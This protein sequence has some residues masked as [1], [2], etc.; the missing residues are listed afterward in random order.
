MKHVINRGIILGSL[1]GVTLSTSLACRPSTEQ[2]GSNL[3]YIQNGDFNCAS[4]PADRLDAVKKKLPA[5]FIEDFPSNQMDTVYN[6]VS[7]IPDVYLD[8]LVSQYKSGVLEGIRTSGGG[9]FGIAGVTTLRSGKS[10]KGVS[11]MVATEIAT[12]P[13]KAGF[14]MQHEIGH[15][16]EI[17]AK[18]A[19]QNTEFKDFSGTLKRINKEIS[20][21]GDARSYAKS[22]PGESWAETYAN[23][24]CNPDTNA[25]IKNNL[26]YTWN[27]V[28]TVLAK[29]IWEEGDDVIAGTTPP[30]P[31]SETPAPA[32]T[33]APAD[34]SSDDGNFFTRFLNNI[35][36]AI[37]FGL[38]SDLQVA[39]I[40][41]EV[42]QDEANKT[43]KMTV[44]LSDENYGDGAIGI[45]F[46]T[47]PEITK[48]SLCIGDDSECDSTQIDAE[49][50]TII[51]T[52]FDQGH[53]RNFFNMKKIESTQAGVLSQTWHLK[54]F[55]SQGQ[56]VEFRSIAFRKQP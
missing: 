17:L 50:R 13:N 10:P 45:A 14:A 52:K 18:E 5:G 41:E 29:P 37:G 48:L 24:Y 40:D 8:Y 16:T 12:S 25:Y 21:R 27:V 46:S 31:A 36:A 49:K 9:F 54:G 33:P 44:A 20:G 26:P 51:L 30:P 19:A 23:Y 22:E 38:T 47:L 28:R 39:D 2:T 15:A 3:D 7:L 4:V 11:G 1:L 55:D 34:S 43:F 53:H 32:P 42:R 56:L 6:R 35:L